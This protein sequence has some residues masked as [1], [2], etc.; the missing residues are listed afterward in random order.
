MRTLLIIM[1]ALT[2]NAERLTDALW[3]DSIAIA[4]HTSLRIRQIRQEIKFHEGIINKIRIEQMKAQKD[5]ATKAML[6]LERH[7][8]AWQTKINRLEKVLKSL[9]RQ[10]LR[11]LASFTMND[12]MIFR[13]RINSNVLYDI[14]VEPTKEVESPFTTKGRLYIRVN[15]GPVHRNYSTYRASERFIKFTH[16]HKTCNITHNGKNFIFNYGSRSYSANRL[17]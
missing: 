7:V 12:A 8:E 2:C 14:V 1:F 9:E 6:D 17:K 16:K 10:H 13:A 4:D 3:V 11:G 5:G 15:N